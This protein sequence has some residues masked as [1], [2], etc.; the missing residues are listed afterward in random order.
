MSKKGDKIV[1]SSDGVFPGV[2]HFSFADVKAEDLTVF[3][4]ARIFCLR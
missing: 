4:A 1:S 3:D 2:P